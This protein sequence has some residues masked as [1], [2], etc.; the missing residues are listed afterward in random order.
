MN[1]IK[2]KLVALEAQVDAKLFNVM[3]GPDGRYYTEEE[4]NGIGLR[5]TGI[6][7]AAGAAIGGYAADRAIMNRYGGGG[8]GMKTR[9]AAYRSAGRDVMETGRFYGGKAIDTGS[10]ALTAG[11]RSWRATKPGAIGNKQGKTK[12]IGRLRK[13]LGKGAGVLSGGRIKFEA[14]VQDRIEFI[15]GALTGPAALGARKKL[16]SWIGRAALGTGRGAGLKQIGPLSSWRQMGAM[17]GMTGGQ[18]TPS[19]AKNLMTGMGAA[20]GGIRGAAA[21]MAIG[22]AGGAIKGAFDEDTSIL[23]GAFKGALGGGALGG[24]AGGTAGGLA[25][26]AL[27][28]RMLRSRRFN[29]TMMS[30]IKERVVELAEGR[31]QGGTAAIF[32]NEIAAA[33]N[34]KKGK[35]LDAFGEAYGHRLGEGLKGGALGTAAGAAAGVGAGAIAAR[36][37]MSRAMRRQVAARAGG[38]LTFV[39]RRNMAR[40]AILSS[41]GRYAGP[42]ALLGL[43]GG[44]GVGSIKGN[45]DKKAREI[46]NKYAE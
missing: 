45:F 31:Y 24:V 20:V 6:P 3:R 5:G 1:E 12:T 2:N 28:G 34:A 41:V 9:M 22:G 38:A 23:G 42:A 33:L 40:K 39:N 35:K 8:S 29:P 15:I 14:Q 37:E 18:I 11:Q 7:A 32:G 25:G 46:R 30:A 36:G 13:A 16:G 17:K 21:G 43:A 10:E 27:A 44:L 4:R 26:R 19:A